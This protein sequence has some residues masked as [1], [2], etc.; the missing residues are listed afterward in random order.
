MCSTSPK[1]LKSQSL[2]HER[3]KQTTDS[4]EILSKHLV[5]GYTYGMELQSNLLVKMFFVL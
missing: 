1:D 4:A 5:N 3:T 2:L